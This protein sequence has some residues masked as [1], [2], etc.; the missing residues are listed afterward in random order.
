MISISMRM[1]R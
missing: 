1:T